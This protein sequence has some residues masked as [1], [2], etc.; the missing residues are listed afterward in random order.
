MAYSEPFWQL[1][2]LREIA[3]AQ[4][5]NVYG[6]LGVEFQ[7]MGE[8]GGGLAA[9]RFVQPYADSWAPGDVRFLHS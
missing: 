2:G 4:E 5:M 7:Y 8:C 3:L 6:A 1:S 9:L